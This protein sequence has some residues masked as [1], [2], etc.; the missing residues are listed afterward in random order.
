MDVAGECS[1]YD[2][3]TAIAQI[4]LKLLGIIQIHN[5]F[6][7]QEDSQIDGLPL[8]TCDKKGD[9]NVIHHYYRADRTVHNWL[10][11]INPQS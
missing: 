9:S 5:S 11:T 1:L 8:P 7:T 3:Y 6:K 10:L 2:E 4:V